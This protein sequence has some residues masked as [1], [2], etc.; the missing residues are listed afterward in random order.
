MHSNICG[1]ITPKSNSHKRYIL[2][3]T[4]DYSHK[5]WTYF[6]HAKLEAFAMFKIFK[7]MVEK[8]KANYISSLRTD[9][10]EEFTSSKFNK[11]CC[12]NGIVRQLNAAFSL[13]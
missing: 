6:L 9:R 5:M 2:T 4:D 3:F 10:G 11:Y 1:P 12:L 7:S 13:Q 8:E